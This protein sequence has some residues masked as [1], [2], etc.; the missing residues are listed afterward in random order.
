MKVLFIFPNVAIPLWDTTPQPPLGLAFVASYLEDFCEVKIIDNYLEKNKL[1]VIMDEISSFN[2]DAI[3]ISMTTFTFESCVE[4]AKSIKNLDEDIVV[5]TGGPHP[6]LFPEEVMAYRCFDATVYGEGELTVREYLSSLVEKR[7]LSHVRGI[8]YRDS[9]GH[10]HLNPPRNYIKNLDKL[11]F[12][13]RHLLP[14]R[15]YPEYKESHSL[16]APVTTMSTSRG[17]PYRCIY[18]S[19]PRIWGGSWRGMSGK[20]IVDEIEHI[21]EKYSIRSI[22]FHEDNFT[23][24][25][26]RVL[27]FCHE[28]LS[29]G[30]DITWQCESRVDNIDNELLESMKKA[31]CQVVWFGIESGSNET[32]NFYKKG[33]TVQHVKEAVKL[34][35]EAG[36]KLMGSFI[37]G[38][39][40]ESIDDMKRTVDFAFRLGLDGIWFN[41]L[42]AFPGTELHDYVTKHAYIHRVLPNNIIQVEGNVPREEVEVLLEI[43]RRRAERYYVKRHWKSLLRYHIR[44]PSK[45]GTKK[46]KSLINILAPAEIDRNNHRE[47]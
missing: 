10:L 12:P 27:D 7:S 22:D 2:P 36:I 17:C 6:S 31:G 47:V 32:L 25:K 8:C 33:T 24:S 37:L 23:L 14:I 20:R 39:P 1:I 9:L 29:R 46:I 41:P 34:T 45:I 42:H 19:S 3:G 43:A 30:L 4:L 21:K 35:R 28:M 18:C 16:E 5:F 15:E 11:K 38:S 44:H 26:K 13:A 40:Y